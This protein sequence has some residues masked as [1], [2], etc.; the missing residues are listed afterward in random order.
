MDVLSQGLV[1]M[2][3][4]GWTLVNFLW[5]GILIGLAYALAR[6]LLPR[7]N[8]RYRMGMLALLMMV[9]CPVAT[10]WQLFGTLDSM[11]VSPPFPVFATHAAV[12]VDSAVM[13][14]PTFDVAWQHGIDNALPWAV[15]AWLIGVLFLSWRTSRQWRRLR[16]MVRMAESLPVWQRHAERMAMRFGLRRPVRIL[17]S[18][19]VTSPV[20]VGWLRPTILLPMTVITKL[21]AAQV[22]WILAHELAHLW[23]WDPLVNLLQVMLETLHFY[24]PVVHWVSRDVRNERELCCDALALSHHGGEPREFAATLAA[25]GE[26]QAAREALLLAA[27]GGLLLE[28]VQQ[29][30]TPESRVA[31]DTHT[32]AHCV[33]AALGVILLAVAL[34]LTWQQ[35][36]ICRQL[37]QSLGV[38]NVTQAQ[39]WQSFIWQLPDLALVRLPAVAPIQVEVSKS[40]DLSPAIAPALPLQI[41]VRDSMQDVQTISSLKYFMRMVTLPPIKP[42]TSAFSAEATP[43]VISIRQPIYPVTALR[44]G[45]KGRVVI[46]FT[47]AASGGVRNMHV[48][49][50]E[51]AGVFERA[52]LQ[53]LGSWRYAMPDRGAT[54]QRYRQALVFDPTSDT[55]SA[56]DEVHAI[57]GACRMVTGSL[58][59]RHYGD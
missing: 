34:Q 31:G 6:V 39:P 51:P 20:L 13:N 4:V 48:V 46:E 17:R 16:V 52:A 41:V 32:S 26:L 36:R 10:A 28:R 2:R 49:A 43:R 44:Q 11:D 50:A 9:L 42:V 22:E 24:H 5:Q 38:W 12:A 35:A 37:V 40:K 8:V 21:P 27:G 15:S 30:T 1:D 7:G 14:V 18:I 45:V 54:S 59:C 23:R 47:L 3:L 19:A 53:A 57:S 25:L 56:V 55:V 29:L 58:I 33:M